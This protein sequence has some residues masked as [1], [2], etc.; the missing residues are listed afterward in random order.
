M[1]TNQHILTT[2]EA[3]LN[4]NKARL[5]VLAGIILGIIKSRD[6]NL[7]TL[8]S[9][10]TSHAKHSSQHKKLYRFFLQWFIPWGDLIAFTLS[11]IPKPEEGYI[12]SIDRTN[13]Q[14]GTM[15]VNI[16]TVGVVVGKAAIPLVWSTLPQTTKRGNSNANQRIELMSKLLKYLPVEEIH[17]LA[18][19]REFHGKKWLKWL[20]NQNLIWVLR[21]KKS[22]LI[23]GT[24]A[25]NLGV[26]RVQDRYQREEVWGLP[27][28]F[29]CKSIL[30]GRDSH[31]Y[32]VSNKFT[33]RE[34]LKAYQKRWAIEVLFGHL[35]KKGF[36][37]ENTHLCQADKMDRLIAVLAL[38]FLFTVGWGLIVKEITTL[39]ATEKR[40]S[41]FR[42]ALDLMRSMLENPIYYKESMILFQQWLAHEIKPSIFVL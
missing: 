38:A 40:K 12:L 31:L 37:L 1:S 39:D 4:S 29:G 41:I 22:T 42:L 26:S 3:S 25:S 10:Q 7:N 33:P 17:F 8:A 11:R 32:V 30:E 28:Y 18:M 5:K 27:L 24:S 36:N 19:D 13:W 21:I 35:K 34:A 2:L 9:Y 20:N 16:L 23:S 14:F 6:V 15:H